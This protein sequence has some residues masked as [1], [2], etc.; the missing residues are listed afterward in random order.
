MEKDDEEDERADK[1]Y[2]NL[3]LEEPHNL[4]PVPNYAGLVKH[5]TAD[6]EEHG[7]PH[8]G[9]VVVE[10]GR[11]RAQLPTQRHDM[12]EHDQEHGEAPH[13]VDIADALRPAC[14]IYLICR[15][16]AAKIVKRL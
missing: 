9:E 2:G 3:L 14:R 13:R 6:E 4:L 8:L 16:G 10:S 15:H 1:L 5:K 12:A 7:H 11:V